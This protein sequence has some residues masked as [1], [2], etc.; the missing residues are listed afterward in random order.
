VAVQ[1]PREEF[2]RSIPVAAL[3]ALALVTPADAQQRATV[4][5]VGVRSIP[6]ASTYWA[7]D[8]G[9][10]RDA[11][12]DVSVEVI[13]S[14]SKAVA[15]IATN[16]MQVG[17][18]GMNAGYFNS[19][20]TGLPITMALDSGS[21][22]LYHKIIVRSG[23]KDSI[24]TIT[25][26]KGRKVGLSSPGSSS[27]YEMGM[28]L[29]SAGLRL[30]DIDVKYLSFTQMGPALL[31]GALDAALEVAPFGEIAIEKKM[32]VDWIDP[33]DHIKQLPLSNVA[34]IANTDWIKN[35]PD[36][37]RRFFVALA[38][39]GRDYCQAYHGGPNRAEMIDVMMK[40]KVVT[41][42]ALVER[43]HWQARDPDGEIAVASVDNQQT[44]YKDE[45]IIKQA[46]AR[47]RLVNTSCAKAAAKELGPF[48]VINTAS[49]LK[50]CR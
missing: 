39:A 4:K 38:R 5:V 32:A 27:V 35:E 36:V 21:T 20:A 14:L 24:K 46:A 40:H 12:L 25:D 19:V 15:F 34:Y 37:A 41:D 45:G 42:R 29:A 16:Q 26:L 50:G 30:K 7:L 33:E 1:T 10:F 13:D 23:L 18:G 49:K 43:M 8:K 44:F 47:D 9:Y 48:K 2:V 31:N 11:N 28:V 17:Q 22:P 6:S 3:L